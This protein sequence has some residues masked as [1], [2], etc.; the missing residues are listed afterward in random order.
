MNNYN[1]SLAD[2]IRELGEFLI[3]NADNMV[4]EATLIEEI[5]FDILIS[6]SNF[7]PAIKSSKIYELTSDN[8]N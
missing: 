7:H 5:E 2:Q 3:K 6:R 8:T 1:T 4:S